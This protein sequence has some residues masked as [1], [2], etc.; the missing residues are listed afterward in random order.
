[1]VAQGGSLEKGRFAVSATPVRFFFRFGQAV[2][3]RS[4]GM[5]N[6]DW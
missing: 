3:A 6:G 4:I 5:H 1:M 2:E